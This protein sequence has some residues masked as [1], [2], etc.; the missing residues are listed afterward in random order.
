VF[1]DESSGHNSG[2][3]QL[4]PES[5]EARFPA[6]SFK[7][8]VLVNSANQVREAKEGDLVVCFD[9]LTW[10]ECYEQG[11]PSV[12]YEDALNGF[13]NDTANELWKVALRWMYHNGN[14]LTL[15]RGVSLGKAFFS[16]VA[17]FVTVSA[18]ISTAIHALIERYRPTHLLLY[19]VDPGHG[20]VTGRHAL[21]LVKQTAQMR[22]LS[23][24]ARQ[25]DAREPSG[26]ETPRSIR[27]KRSVNWRI[28]LLHVVFSKA[29]GFI[30]VL[31][32]L[33]RKPRVW[34]S[35]G[36]T[37]LVPMMDPSR[38]SKAIPLGH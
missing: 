13:T 35:A 6:G 12:F 31:A 26:P 14:D 4:W 7:T 37:L 30:S 9:W 25:A 33:R 24:E 34:L 18:R 29:V 2:G 17:D 5:R 15:F 32:S 3:N 36:K 10:F 20:S 38:S 16:E 22:G 8:L 1:A 28:R 23:F 21:N 27:M 19:A 11:L